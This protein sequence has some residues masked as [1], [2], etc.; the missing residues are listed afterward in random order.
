MTRR[1]A[2]RNPAGKFNYFRETADAAKAAVVARRPFGV[3]WDDLRRD[4][5]RCVKVNIKVLQDCSA[6]A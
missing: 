6:T 1:F 4:G 2:I 5:Y 3:R